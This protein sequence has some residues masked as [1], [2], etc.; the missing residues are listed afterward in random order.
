[1]DQFQ[2]LDEI[3]PDAEKQD[4]LDDFP[5]EDPIVEVYKNKKDAASR[6]RRPQR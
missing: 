6:T 3:D 4:E 1:M 2:T 5:L